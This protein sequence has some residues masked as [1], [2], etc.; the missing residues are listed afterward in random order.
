M[1]AGYVA[2]ASESCPTIGVACR[3]LGGS[4]GAD[5]LVERLHAGQP[6]GIGQRH[7][8]SRSRIPAFGEASLALFFAPAALSPTASRFQ[9]GAERA[10]ADAAALMREV[11]QVFDLDFIKIAGEH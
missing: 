9:L 11:E 1:E 5:N 7:R 6:L 8:Y 4:A 10:L 2:A 3:R